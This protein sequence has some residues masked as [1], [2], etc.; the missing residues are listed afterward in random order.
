M[1]VDFEIVATRRHKFY[2]AP[3]N[4]STTHIRMCRVE[5]SDMQDRYVRFNV[6]FSHGKAVHI[7]R[8]RR[9]NMEVIFF[10]V[11][12]CH[13]GCTMHIDSM[14]AVCVEL[15]GQLF[16]CISVFSF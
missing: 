9:G 8:L 10:L 5:S 15:W 7:H 4:S 16:D 2:G 13:T 14:G 11:S 3:A 1:Y 6:G 12:G